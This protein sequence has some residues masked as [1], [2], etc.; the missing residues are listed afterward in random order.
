M[1][2]AG[3]VLIPEKTYKLNISQF[4]GQKARSCKATG[5]E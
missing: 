1:N 2:A 4:G 3:V 5:K